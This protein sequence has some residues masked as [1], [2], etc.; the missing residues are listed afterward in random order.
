M[1]IARKNTKMVVTLWWLS[2]R[3][4]VAKRDVPGKRTYRVY[5]SDVCDCRHVLEV[6]F[7]F[8]RH[9]AMLLNSLFD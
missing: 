8:W 4:S 5:T 1:I 7:V 3:R 6:F 2:G 9:F